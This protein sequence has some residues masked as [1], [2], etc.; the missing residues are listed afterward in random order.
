MS[1]LT[2]SG[3]E[4]ADYQA[5][6]AVAIVNS[7][8]QKLND[9]LGIA[10]TANDG[11]VTFESQHNDTT[12]VLHIKNSGG[13]KL[14]EVLAD[15]TVFP[16]LAPP[17]IVHEATQ[18]DATYT[19]IADI[20]NKEFFEFKPILSLSTDASVD[21]DQDIRE[22]TIQGTEYALNGHTW[23]HSKAVLSSATNAGVG[24]IT[25]ARTSDKILTV[26]GSTTNPDF[27]GLQSGQECIIIGDI[28]TTS[29]ADFYGNTR[30]ITESTKTLLTVDSVSTNAITFIEDLP[31]NIDVLGASLTILPSV[32]IT[33]DQTIKDGQIIHYKHVIL[34]DNVVVSSM[35]CAAFENCVF[36]GSD[37]ALRNLGKVD[38]IGHENTIVACVEGILND[39]GSLDGHITITFG[40]I[41]NTATHCQRYGLYNK[42]NGRA[43]L[44]KYR[45]SFTMYGLLNEA[46]CVD[47]DNSELIHTYKDAIWNRCNGTAYIR[48]GWA[49]T[50]WFQGVYTQRRSV[51]FVY[52]FTGGYNNDSSSESVSANDYNLVS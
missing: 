9:K 30:N 3:L 39:G 6:G 52:N 35:G 12:P 43:M 31:T 10:F 38:F 23:Y 17:E 16:T 20:A 37:L 7:N 11:E 19:D 2:P 13:T 42:N 25:F 32:H 28:T 4:T 51:S 29:K 34:D 1:I 45:C 14:F 36:S 5:A 40:D 21:L 15:G 47:A 41:V 48:S 44:D 22:M 18:E 26:T 50:S 27:T 33:N 49:N 46:S 24:T 8:A